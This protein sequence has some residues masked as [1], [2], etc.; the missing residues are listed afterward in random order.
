MLPIYSIIK[1][2]TLPWI[3]RWENVA[4]NPS[5]FTV[6]ESV[7]LEKSLEKSL[8]E[9]WKNSE[10]SA[11]VGGGEGLSRVKE[12]GDGRQ[13]EEAGLIEELGVPTSIYLKEMYWTIYK[14]LMYVCWK[15]HGFFIIRLY[16]SFFSRGIAS[17]S[18][19]TFSTSH[20]E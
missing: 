10:K 12:A 15:D 20:K 1:Y 17:Y 18:H 4:T 7:R 9:A 3:V 16:V 13:L 19:N 2:D 11:V 5:N 6:P 8:V 14:Y